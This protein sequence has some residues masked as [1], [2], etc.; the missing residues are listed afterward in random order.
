MTFKVVHSMAVPNMPIEEK[1]ITD[2]GAELVKGVFITEDQIIEACKDADAVI[3]GATAQPITRKVIESLPKCRIFANIG[4]G[5]DQL[6]VQAATDNGMIAANVPDYC[7][8]EVSDTAM[9]L[10]LSLYRKMPIATAMTAEGKLM[11]MPE[12][13]QKMMPIFRLKGRVLGL[14]G[15]G[16][17]GRAMVPK[18]QG[19]GMKVI[20]YDPYIPA[21]A[22]KEIGVDLVEKDA[23]LGQADYLSLHAPAGPDGKPLIGADELAKM[24]PTAYLINTA[25][26]SLVDEAA[27]VAALDAGKLAGAGL[28]VTAQEPLPTD[29]PL[30]G[31]D[32][33]ILTGHSAQI[34]VEATMELFRRPL[35]EVARV[36]KGEWPVGLINPGVKEKFVAKFGPMK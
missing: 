25:R 20:A 24:K 31:R 19:F 36:L 28:D 23:L 13:T 26:G 16:R 29:S 34:S 3:G 6:D 22:A 10:L 1:I 35:V 14:L 12:N 8:D 27:L 5:Y 7:L 32:N 9:T 21:E 33:V 2:A 4:I 15:L 17:I 11:A 18:A 30:L